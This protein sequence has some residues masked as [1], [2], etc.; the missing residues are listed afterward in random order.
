MDALEQETKH[1]KGSQKTTPPKADH[2]H[3]YYRII[4]FNRIRRFDGTITTEKYKFH[5][6]TRCID[7]GHRNSNA[8]HTAIEVEVSVREFKKLE[9]EEKR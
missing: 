2:K 4:T 1:V 3:E 9:R 7:C 6:P 8:Y 5:L